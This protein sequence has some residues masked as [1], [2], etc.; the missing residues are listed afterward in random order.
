MN[1]GSRL[2]QALIGA[3][4]AV[5]LA[6]AGCQL[7]A[8]PADGAPVQPGFDRFVEAPDG[9]GGPRRISMA[10]PSGDRSTSAVLLEKVLPDEVLK[11]RPFEVLLVVRNLTD[12]PLVDVRLT[13]RVP[14]ALSVLS[15]EPAAT[16]EGDAATWDLGQLAP[17][18]SKTVR[19]RAVADAPAK[20]A[21]STT[22][23]YESRLDAAIEVTD[24][25]LEVRLEAPEEALRTVPFEM[26]VTVSNVGTGDARG[27]RVQE[28]LPD[29]LLTSDGLGRIAMDLGTIE[30]ARS[31]SRSVTL[32]AESA[33]PFVQSV[34]ARS[35]AGLEASASP[36]TTVVRMPRLDLEMAGDAEVRAG[37]PFGA[38]L[39]LANMGD[40]TS[41][42]TSVEVQ[43][44]QGVRALEVSEGGGV[45]GGAVRWRIGPLAPGESASFDL[46]MRAPE[47]GVLVTEATAS[48]RG[49]DA[50]RAT[51]RTSVEGVAALGLTVSDG[52]DLVPVGEEVTYLI[53][54]E[55]EGAGADE[56]VT[57][58]ATLEEGIEFVRSAGAAD[59]VVEGRTV[60][61]DPIPSLAP[62]ARVELRVV[63][64]S[65]VEL[66]SRF[67]VE[68]V[69]ATETRPITQMESTDFFE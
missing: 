41:E 40:G 12:R 30:E 35:A 22:V 21:T 39:R 44:P 28:E 16:V 65:S 57:V 17:R 53:V 69:S 5:A 38:T 66:D 2:L 15:R 48:G 33:G 59:A 8:G 36:V 42:S 1:T 67:L 49:A 63:A 54:V 47:G 3:L 64:R 24:P 31:V 62:G 68:V 55:N 50:A 45:A 37:R 26:V 43:L 61:F 25:V 23:E 6:S 51:L 52:S 32:R 60:R 11:G 13:D 20:L 4:L 34:T 29:G 9:P 7:P 19:I 46:R 14:A 18:A 27:V 10:F 56:A 58:T